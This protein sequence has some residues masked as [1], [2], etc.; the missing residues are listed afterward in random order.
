[1]IYKVK[2]S[3]ANI[4]VEDAIHEFSIMNEST[5]RSFLQSFKQ[6]Q[7]IFFLIWRFALLRRI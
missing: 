4:A 5:N 6:R 1:M 7:V 3:R 2:K